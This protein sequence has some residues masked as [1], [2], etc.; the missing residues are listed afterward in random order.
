MSKKYR[1]PPFVM[2]YRD[3]L[4]DPDWRKLSNS[5]KIVYIYLRSKFNSSD[6]SEVGLSYSEIKDMISSATLSNA[7]KELT[8]KK[9]IE[10]TKYG[11]LFGGVCKYKFVGKYKDFFYK[12]FRV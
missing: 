8:T 6:L 4:K 2:I 11:G 3:M 7:F 1:A 10:K 12:G 5:A 9:W